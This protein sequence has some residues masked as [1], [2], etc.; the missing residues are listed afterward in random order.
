MDSLPYQNPINTYR[1]SSYILLLIL[2]PLLTYFRD[3]YVEVRVTRS[4][5][6]TE[7]HD[8]AGPS[9]DT[10]VRMTTVSPILPTPVT[11]RP[12]TFHYEIPDVSEPEDYI[13]RSKAQLIQTELWDDHPTLINW[14]AAP[15]DKTIYLR[16]DHEAGLTEWNLY[17]MLK[18]RFA[19]TEKISALR[20][21]DFLF[22]D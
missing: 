9:S 2:C 21:K 18:K 5:S 4:S 8:S 14:L 17:D 20:D 12:Q 3:D 11:F 10:P 7:S 15:T 13:D 22:N 16:V 1:N 19:Q 6:Q